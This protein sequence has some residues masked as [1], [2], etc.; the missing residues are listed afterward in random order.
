MQMEEVRGAA[1]GGSEEGKEGR[2][3]EGD[4]WV[5]GLRLSLKMTR[6]ISERAELKG[7]CFHLIQLQIRVLADD[8]S[9]RKRQSACKRTSFVQPLPKKR[10][11]H[12]RREISARCI[13]SSS[14]SFRT[15]YRRDN[16][17]LWRRSSFQQSRPSCSSRR[18][19]FSSLS[20]SLCLWISL[21]LTQS[22]LSLLPQSLPLAWTN[23]FS[24]LSRLYSFVPFSVLFLPLSKE[25]VL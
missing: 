5:Y 22:F 25:V 9:I 10:C 18:V 2:K 20:F 14:G 1:R 6:E 4:G 13:Y 16:A 11:G 8:K 23:T 19:K 7:L 15:S 17:V 24:I 21:C 3:A 12:R